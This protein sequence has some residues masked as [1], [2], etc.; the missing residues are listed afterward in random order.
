MMFADMFKSPCVSCNAHCSQLFEVAGG[1]HWLQI[2]W[3][4]VNSS[5]SALQT[6]WGESKSG[7]AM[8]DA[9]SQNLL[10]SPIDGHPY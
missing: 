3:F 2:C 8:L 5:H 9:H 10:L 6:E 7:R 1:A 4:K